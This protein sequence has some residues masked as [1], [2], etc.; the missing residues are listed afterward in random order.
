MEAKEYY[1]SEKYLRAQKRVKAIKGFYWHFA[2]YI[3]VCLFIT[4]SKVNRNILNGESL[5]DSIWDTSTFFV[6]IP[7]GVGVAFHALGVF[8]IPFLFNKEWEE[9][10]IKKFMEEE[11]KNYKVF[12]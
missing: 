10:K 9:Q 3:I 6:W 1:N 7:W 12:K 5:W 4:I 8:G 11:E 2:I